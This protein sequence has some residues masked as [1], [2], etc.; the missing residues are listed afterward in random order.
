MTKKPRIR[1]LKPSQAAPVYDRAKASHGVLRRTTFIMVLCGILLFI[2][3]IWQLFQLMILDHDRYESSAISNQTRTTP[4]S[5]N[6]GVI[7]DCNMNILAASKTVENV[8]LDPWEIHNA[9]EDVDFI[10]ENLARIL[11][12]DADLI[13]EKAAKLDRR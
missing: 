7:Y 2:P 13:R 3:L 9:E 10:A 12:I 6:R 11:D 1:L 5:A 8:F 4:V